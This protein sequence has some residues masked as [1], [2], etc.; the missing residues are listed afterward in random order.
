MGTGKGRVGRKAQPYTHMLA[1]R[2][3]VSSVAVGEVIQYRQNGMYGG[4]LLLA[5]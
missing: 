1:G 2:A 3:H 4:C 5:G